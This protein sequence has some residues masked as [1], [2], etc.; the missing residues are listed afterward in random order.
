[1][2][3]HTTMPVNFIQAL[4]SCVQRVLPVNVHVG[5]KRKAVKLCLATASLPSNDTSALKKTKRKAPSRKKQIDRVCRP[6]T[7]KSA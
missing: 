2:V 5:R 4:P 6:T 1:V 7:A 3:A